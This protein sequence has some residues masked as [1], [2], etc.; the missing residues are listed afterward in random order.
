[1]RAMWGNGV[2]N[3]FRFALS[4]AAFAGLSA[5]LVLGSPARADSPA[6]T[7][8]TPGDAYSGAPYTLGF[9]FMPNG[10]QTLTALGT[11]SFN[12]GGPSGPVMVG[13]WDT[14]GTLLASATVPGGTGGMQI[15]AFWYE[16]I[17]PFDLVGGTDYIIGSYNPDD[18]SSYNT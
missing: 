2:M 5:L 13:L 16:A 4:A 15:G 10:N 11:F 6:L 12:A 8:T 3:R 17:T 18:Q 7:I 9:E 1:D 14:T